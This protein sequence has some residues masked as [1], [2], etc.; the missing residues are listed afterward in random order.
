[1]RN[2]MMRGPAGTGKTEAAKAIAAGLGLPYLSYT[3]SANTEIYDFLG[4]CFRKM[5]RS[6]RC[7]EYPTFLDLQMDP[8][9]AY[10]KLTGIYK[11]DVSEDEVYQK[12]LEVMETDARAESKG[13][14]TGQRFRY[15]ETPLVEAMKMAMSS[16]SRSLP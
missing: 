3:C 6:H 9:S 5:K 1:M 12:L 7:K 10:E 8:S 15:V 11:D 16:R 13:A 14:S 2:F 4:R